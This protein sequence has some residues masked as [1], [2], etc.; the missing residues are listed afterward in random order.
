MGGVPIDFRMTH[1]RCQMFVSNLFPN[2]L[3]E[4]QAP[5]GRLRQFLIVVHAT[6]VMHFQYFYQKYGTGNT[7]TKVM[8]DSV[9]TSFDANTT[10]AINMLQHW[11]KVV[12][13]DF[14]QSNTV[15]NDGDTDNNNLLRRQNFQDQLLKVNANVAVHLTK[16]IDMHVQFDHMSLHLNNMHSQVTS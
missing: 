15:G 16:W 14:M 1:D 13:D 10:T 11:S 5:H 3:R 6:M 9:R 7:Y 12:K 8:I 4:F 2:S